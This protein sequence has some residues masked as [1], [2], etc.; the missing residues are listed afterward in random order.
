MAT[1]LMA[2]LA[3]WMVGTVWGMMTG[4][5]LRGTF[6]RGTGDG[7]RGKVAESAVFFVAV[8]V[9]RLQGPYAWVYCTSWLRWHWS[10]VAR[11]QVPDSGSAGIVPGGLHPITWIGPEL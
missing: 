3:A 7:L 5:G 9:I 8:A 11:A 6:S 1:E 2:V 10:Q 4:R